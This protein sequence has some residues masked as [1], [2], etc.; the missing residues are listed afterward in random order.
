M[1][2]GT[3]SSDPEW[4]KGNKQMKAFD[5]MFP[6]HQS[7]LTFSLRASRLPMNRGQKSLKRGL[8]ILF[9]LSLVLASTLTY[10]CVTGTRFL[11]GDSQRWLLVTMKATRHNEERLYFRSTVQV[12][13]FQN[14]PLDPIACSLVPRPPPSYLLLAV[15]KSGESLL[16]HVS[17]M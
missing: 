4:G 13:H 1:W 17:T 11:V 10:S 8:S 5:G 3:L 6:Q 14:L 16:S 12:R 15:R 7:L 2:G 9:R